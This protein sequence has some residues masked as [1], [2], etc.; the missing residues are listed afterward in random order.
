MSVCGSAVKKMTESDRNRPS[1]AGNV[2]GVAYA[3]QKP[4]GG[5]RIVTTSSRRRPGGRGLVRLSNPVDAGRGL[6]VLC[7]AK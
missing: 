1:G 5:E 3:L 6:P 7:R 2:R 4:P